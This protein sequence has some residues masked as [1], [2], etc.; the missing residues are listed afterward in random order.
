MIIQVID[1]FGKAVARK[2]CKNLFTAEKWLDY[3]FPNRDA[4]GYTL[5]VFYD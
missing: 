2:R 3:R 5:E 4:L 1:K